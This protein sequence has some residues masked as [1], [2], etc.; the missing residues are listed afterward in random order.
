MLCAGGKKLRD[1]YEGD[2][3]GPLTCQHILSIEAMSPI[4]AGS[5]RGASSISSSRIDCS[6]I[7]QASE[8]AAAHAAKELFGTKF[9]NRT[10]IMAA[11]LRT[12]LLLERRLNN[13]T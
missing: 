5:S 2:A 9:R 11:V 12:Y 10:L 6:I 13:Q 1:T 7:Y 3:G 8:L 4:F